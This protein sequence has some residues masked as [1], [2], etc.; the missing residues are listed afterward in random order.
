MSGTG[1]NTPAGTRSTLVSLALAV[2]VGASIGLAIGRFLPPDS[3]AA[4]TGA[5][6]AAAPRVIEHD[7]AGADRVLFDPAAP[8]VSSPRAVHAEAPT[9]PL[10][11]L[12]PFVALLA[13]IALMPFVA[14][15][16]WG[17]RYGE[18]ALALGG[19]TAG[20]FLARYG[21][22]GR[23]AMLHAVREYVSFIALVGGLYV[24]SG[25]I[26]VQV[27]GRATPLVNTGLLA[28]GALLANLV[29]TTGAS[30]LLLN[31]FIRLNQGRIRSI[32]IVMFI[33]IV[34]NCGGALTPIGDPPLY[35]GFLNGVPFTWTAVH[36]FPMWATCV[37][38]L[39][40]IFLLI[41]SMF[42][43]PPPDDP[44]RFGV[45]IAGAPA[46]A[47]LV[48]IV[49]G[50]F[51]DP[52]LEAAF[53]IT[54]VPV[55]PLVQ[56]LVAAGAWLLADRKIQAA[57]RFSFHPV[58]EVGLLFVGIFATMAPALWYMVQNGPRF[59]LVSPAQYYFATGSL[60]AALDNAPTY[61]N[62]LQMALGTLHI[63][64][65]PEGVRRV[66]AHSY[67]VVGPG[68]E[69]SRFT[70]NELIAAISL[71]AVF[72]G[73]MTYIGNGPNFMVKAIAEDE[74]VPMPGFLGY[75]LRAAVILFPVLLLVRW[76]FLR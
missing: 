33:F 37:G 25:G 50:V 76:L 74:G 2:L 71:G 6:S 26:L 13:S 73:A 40:L 65:D 19:L 15:K 23:H 14:P 32:H 72:F 10:W 51:I 54:G 12:A 66:L 57:N 8:E 61:L 43:P 35:L 9:I 47:A 49:A 29:G 56:V 38:A 75:V 18:V 21:A 62:F 63:P 58:R 17:V 55:G 41:D 11:Q 52:G 22:F 44:R 20:C 28:F 7:A 64:A 45:T 39:L 34:S 4:A 67:T 68:G 70:G 30:V 59:G 53:G 1:T 42:V 16:W 31:P 69:A 36:L 46:M 5:A 60:S 48:I 24:V 27:R 3:H